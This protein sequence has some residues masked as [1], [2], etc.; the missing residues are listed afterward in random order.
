MG[1]WE[2][3]Q[4]DKP[5]KNMFMIVFLPTC[6]LVFL[7]FPY[8]KWGFVNL[9]LQHKLSVIFVKGVAVSGLADQVV[10]QLVWLK[11]L[12]SAC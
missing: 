5:E 2:Q 1:G 11:F 10:C 6:P 7:E 3:K 4:K 8:A 12:R 9:L